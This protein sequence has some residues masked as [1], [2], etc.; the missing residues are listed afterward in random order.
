MAE[1]KPEKIVEPKLVLTLL[2]LIA[3]W[4]VFITLVPVEPTQKEGT[5]LLTIKAVSGEEIILNK[6][7]TVEKGSNAFDAMKEAATV[8][9]QDYGEMGV[10]VESINEV[11]PAENQFWKLFVNQEEAALGIS[12]ITI[13]QDTN[14]E[15]KIEE[16]ENFLG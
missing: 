10:M 3:I 7:I 15:W 5:V 8:G 16:I 1:A 6:M 4:L 12:A 14:I 9:F 11:T 13:E 2:A